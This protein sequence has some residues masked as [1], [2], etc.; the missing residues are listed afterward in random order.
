MVVFVKQVR[1]SEGVIDGK[2]GDKEYNELA[3][4]NCCVL[5]CYSKFA[6]A[7]LK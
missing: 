5:F 7:V 1:G 4:V 3:D 6:V 2:S